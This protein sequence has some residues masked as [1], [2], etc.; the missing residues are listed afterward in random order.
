MRQVFAK[1]ADMQA[2]SLPTPLPQRLFH[3]AKWKCS[4]V[5]CAILCGAASAHAAPE[6]WRFDPV[7][8]QIWFSADHEHFSRPLGRLRIKDGWFQ[9]DDKD[10]SASH[11]DVVIDLTSA[12]M[13]DAKWS[14]TVKSGQLLDTERWASAHFVSRSV[15]QKDAKDGVIHGD[16]TFHGE[17]KPVDV[18]F[19]L[20]RI[21]TDPYIFRQ[22]AGFSATATLHRSEFGMQRYADVVGEDIQLRFEIEGIRDR[23]AANPTQRPRH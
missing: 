15:E 1:L 23:D 4:I 11:V 9:F 22:K 10:W 3:G 12:D 8:S 20:N 18:A 17:T 14:A 6:T 21:G 5:A 7:H 19:T 13:G 2:T 16:L